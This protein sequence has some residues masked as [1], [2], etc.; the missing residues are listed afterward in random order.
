MKKIL[1][2]DNKTRAETGRLET[3]NPTWRRALAV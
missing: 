2:S 3:R 1:D